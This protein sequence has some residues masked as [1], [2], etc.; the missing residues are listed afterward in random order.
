[1]ADRPVLRVTVQAAQRLALGTGSEVSYYT[2]THSFVPGSVLRGALA[3]AW[4]A[5]HGPPTAAGSDRTRF[6]YLFDGPIR[7]GAR[8][9][10][11]ST[12]TP[13]SARV[14]KYPKSPE[15]K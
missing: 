10:P 4:I 7:Y 9:V 8:R 15:C 12:V 5:E 11:G 2:G 13:V 6:R 3:A 1:M 14:C